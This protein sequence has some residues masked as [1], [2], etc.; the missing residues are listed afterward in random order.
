MAFASV[1]YLL[2]LFN[3]ALILTNSPP[4]ELLTFSSFGRDL[5]HNHLKE[6][7]GSIFSSAGILET[8]SVKCSC[9]HWSS[10]FLLELTTI[11]RFIVQSNFHFT[12]RSVHYFTIVI[13]TVCVILLR[14]FLIIVLAGLFQRLFFSHCSIL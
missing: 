2:T 12:R 4:A 13:T 1:I 8:L 3:P 10:F 6:L 14:K 5:S 9:S 11:Q 7:S